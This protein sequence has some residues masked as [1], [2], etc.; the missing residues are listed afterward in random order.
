MCV[1]IVVGVRCLL[2]LSILFISVS[3]FCVCVLHVCDC[4][5]CVTVCCVCE[6]VKIKNNFMAYILSYLYAGSGYQSQVF[7]LACLL[8]K[9]S[10]LNYITCPHPPFF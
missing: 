2:L 8:A 5:V 9:L 6:Y 4:V 10:Y 3:V 7:A 1:C